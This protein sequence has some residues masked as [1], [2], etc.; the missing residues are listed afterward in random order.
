[1]F[2]IGDKP[3]CGKLGEDLSFPNVS[4]PDRRNR[5]VSRPSGTEPSHLAL[6]SSRNFK[7][8]PGNR[9][10]RKRG[11]EI[12]L[13]NRDRLLTN[14]RNFERRSGPPEIFTIDVRSNNSRALPKLTG[15][16]HDQ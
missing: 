8:H 7:L 16:L 3:E 5:D 13:R 2:T 1:M 9:V 12:S 6:E 15:R 11:E 14:H 4:H 10:K